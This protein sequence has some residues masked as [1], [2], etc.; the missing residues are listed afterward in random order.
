MSGDHPHIERMMR[1]GLTPDE[2][3]VNE[4]RME[5]LAQEHVRDLME[6]EEYSITEAVYCGSYVRVTVEDKVPIE[7]LEE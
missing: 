3:P 6:G 5:A 4:D 1:T 7:G 2:R